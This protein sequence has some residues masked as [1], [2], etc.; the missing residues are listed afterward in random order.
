MVCVI[1]L[2]NYLGNNFILKTI[3]LKRLGIAVLLV[4]FFC[5]VFAQN[6][7]I[8]GYVQSLNNENKKEPLPYANIHW[9]DTNIGVVADSSGYFEIDQT[10]NHFREIVISFV[11]YKSD[12]VT[13]KDDNEIIE[14]IL[15]NAGNLDEIIVSGKQ[16]ARSISAI[17]PLNIEVIT[18]DGLQRLAC[19]S[20]AG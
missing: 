18:S 12:T 14:I 10:T 17:N 6:P 9:L 2:T 7:L 16:D 3:I 8:K 15:S 5:Q 19:C 13:I 4:F 20:L 11:G 1:K